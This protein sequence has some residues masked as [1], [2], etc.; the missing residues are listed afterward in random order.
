MFQFKKTRGNQANPKSRQKN[1]KKSFQTKKHGG[2]LK[3]NNKK[4]VYKTFFIKE[5]FFYI[6]KEE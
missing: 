4:E 2:R 6:K 1:S 5:E 3:Q